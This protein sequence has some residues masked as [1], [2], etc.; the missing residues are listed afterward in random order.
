MRKMLYGD[1]LRSLTRMG[2][3]AHEQL[4]VIRSYFLCALDSALLEVS[5][6]RPRYKDLHLQ[7]VL[8]DKER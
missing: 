2:V 4:R 8:L 3:T 6:G 5:A 7:T 1:G